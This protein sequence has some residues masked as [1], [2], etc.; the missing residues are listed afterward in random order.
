MLQTDSKKRILKLLDP[1]NGM[2]DLNTI[3]PSKNIPKNAS[4]DIGNYPQLVEFPMCFDVFNTLIFLK[5]NNSCKKQ[6]IFLFY[7]SSL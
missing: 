4:I 5:V 3:I 2:P 7:G 1:W 6:Y